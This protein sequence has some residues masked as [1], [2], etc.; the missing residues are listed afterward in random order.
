MNLKATAE[1]L[2]IAQYP[3]MLDTVSATLAETSSPVGDTALIEALQK[4]YCLFGE[5]CDDVL[6]GARDLFRDPDRLCWARVVCGAL[7]K[8]IG[9]AH[10]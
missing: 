3:P 7:E 2:G 10:V 4:E 5:Y 6:A 8:E 9:R 1:R